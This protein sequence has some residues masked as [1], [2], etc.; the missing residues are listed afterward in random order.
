MKILQKSISKIC[1]NI[2]HVFVITATSASDYWVN[3]E[4]CPVMLTHPAAVAMALMGAIF[5]IK[6]DL[7][8]QNGNTDSQMANILTHC[9]QVI[10]PY[11]LIAVDND[12]S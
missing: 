1:F 3:P 10:W 6:F 7:M 4:I 9:G 8:L 12:W 5:F 11:S 2:T